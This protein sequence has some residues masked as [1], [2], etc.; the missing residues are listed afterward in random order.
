MDNTPLLLF[1][2]GIVASKRFK[3]TWQLSEDQKFAWGTNVEVSGAIVI[4]TAEEYA[5]LTPKTG[6]DRE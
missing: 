2:A 5:A 1:T 3:A 6:A 4:M